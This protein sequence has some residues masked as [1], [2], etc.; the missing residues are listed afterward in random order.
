MEN[1]QAVKRLF[2]FFVMAVVMTGCGSLSSDKGKTEEKNAAENNP[3]P[4]LRQ[5]NKAE[6]VKAHLKA[7]VASLESGDMTRAHRH[8]E[9]ALELDE[10]SAE[11]HNALAIFYQVE[12]DH[13]QAEKHFKRALALD[14]DDS[15]I[16]HN[17]G[18]FV[19]RQGR[20]DE[21][22]EYLTKAASDYRYNKRDETYESLGRCEMFA[23]N[24]DAAEAAF[25]HSYRLN[26]KLPKTL[27]GLATIKFQKGQNKL[28]YD[29]YQQFIQLSKQNAQSLWLGIR[30]ERVFGNKDAQA[31]YELALRRLYP[32]SKEYQLYQASLKTPQSP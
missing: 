31:S 17:Y 23:G 2:I 8:L 24:I 21:A 16:N 6:A 1:V 32:G 15:S 25:E 19:C 20:Y 29:H 11:V 26:Q 9:R 3:L 28:A 27:L 30:L 12:K 7:G 4:K 14:S 5:L 18:S 22:R 13:E 10:K